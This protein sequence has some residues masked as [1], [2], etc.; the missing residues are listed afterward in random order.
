[1]PN[2]CSIR[3]LWIL[4]NQDTVVFSRR[5]P[6]VEKRWRAACERDKSSIVE[7]DL[8]YN[9]VPSL[10]TDS[11]IAAAF[12]DRKQREGS[13]RGFGI[14]I[15]QSVEGSDSWVD[16]P[17]TR[18]IISLCIK[19]EEEEK[20]RIVWPLVL[21]IKGLYCILVLPLVGPDHLKVYTRMRKRSDCGDAVG[22]DEN[23]SPFLLNLPSIT[24]AFMV[25]HMIGDIITGDVTEPEIVISASPSVGGL[26]DSLTGSIGIS[27]RAKPVAAPV[28]G[29]AASGAATSGAMTSDAPKIGLRPLDRDAIRSFI[30]SAMPFGTPLDL[31]YTNI[32]AVKINGFSSADIPP[33]DQKQPAWKPYLYRGKQRILFT[34]HETVHVAMYDRDEIPDSKKISGQV[35]CR[36]ELEGLPDVM[37][38]L[39]GLDTARVELLSFHPC[40]QVPEHGNEK[41]SL[42][43]SPPL[44]N[45]VLMRY[46]AFCGM[47]PPI[48][49]FYQLSMVSENEG[50]FLFKLR[51]MEGYRAPLSMDFCTVTMPFPRRRVLSFDGTPSIGT[52]AVAEHLV[53][54][55]II[56]TG[57]GVSGKSVEATFP[58]TVKFAPWQPQRLP[59]SG[60]VLGNMEDE[61]SDAETESTYN[62][63]N[64]E[65]LLME[66]MNKDLQAVDLEEPFC[67]QAY[68]Y[69][70]VS[71]FP[72]V[73][74]PVEFS[75]Q[76]TSGDYILWNTLGKCPVAAT[77][78]A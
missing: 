73:K 68:D 6:V 28:A 71:I 69:A 47:G 10:P 75:T 41:Q 39:I 61:E 48:K 14:R 63:A 51:L 72:A 15:N 2:S 46:Q 70:K 62:M 11:E 49:G 35:N 36:A 64:V 43:F 59:T 19:K 56:T 34:I 7:D 44:G 8:K 20:N 67:W 53:E 31:N 42:M 13:A 1:M 60:A 54:W 37:F 58:G 24:G 23:L 25:G 52:V 33:A 4:T 9:V 21:H 29:S 77:P 78:K 38:P 22:A 55:K 74:A 27:A 17:I 65:E 16:D 12:I 3:A 18:H 57:R 66:K 26:L 40:A 5:F 32:S 76:V 50:A 45:F 30:S